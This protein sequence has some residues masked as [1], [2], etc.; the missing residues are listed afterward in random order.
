MKLHGVDVCITRISTIMAGAPMMNVRLILLLHS[1]NHK[2]IGTL[3]TDT[4][5]IRENSRTIEISKIPRGGF[6][7][8]MNLECSFAEA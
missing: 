3:K 5:V 1:W 2:I 4:A 7:P 8:L 6:N